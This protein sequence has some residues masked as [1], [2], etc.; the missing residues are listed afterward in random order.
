MSERLGGR[1]PFF[2]VILLI[3]SLSLG[4]ALLTANNLLLGTAYAVIGMLW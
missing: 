2:G 4:V 3:A 1:W